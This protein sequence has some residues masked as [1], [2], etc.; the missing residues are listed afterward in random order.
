MHNHDLAVALAAL[1][2]EDL[3][4]VLVSALLR[5]PQGVDRSAYGAVSVLFDKPANEDFVPFEVTVAIPNDI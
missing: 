5:H 1:P 3:N 2:I 4:D